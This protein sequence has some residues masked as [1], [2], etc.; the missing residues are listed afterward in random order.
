[1]ATSNESRL[2]TKFTESEL[3]IVVFDNIY[4]YTHSLHSPVLHDLMYQF[5]SNRAPIVINILWYCF[6]EK[7][8]YLISTNHYKN[9][10]TVL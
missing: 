4:F 5:C 1:M 6:S 9:V 3:F 8:C 7:M 2:S 10:G